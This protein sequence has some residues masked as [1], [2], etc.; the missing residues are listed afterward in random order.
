MTRDKKSSF[1]QD[2]KLPRKPGKER[3]LTIQE[4]E[5]WGALSETIRPLPHAKLEWEGAL[6]SLPTSDGFTLA[7]LPDF[8]SQPHKNPETYPLPTLIND[9]KWIRQVREGT[10]LIEATLDLHGKTEEQAFKTFCGFIESA[11]MQGKRLVL[12]ITGRGRAGEGVLRRALPVWVENTA[13]KARIISYCKAAV[14]HGGDGAF[15]LQL[16]KNRL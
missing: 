14:P 10:E 5:E 8:L 13:M 1:P 6:E 7:N 16:R 4:V 2:K 3:K 12:V 15:Y 9:R 11:H